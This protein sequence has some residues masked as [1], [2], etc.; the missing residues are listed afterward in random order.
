MEHEGDYDTNCNW[1]RRNGPQR[2]VKG[3]GSV[4]NRRTIHDHLNY[5]TVKIG[6]N[7]ERRLPDT[8]KF[9]VI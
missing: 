3:A 5:N 6:R 7:T 9:D 2:I 4:E 8:R 1:C